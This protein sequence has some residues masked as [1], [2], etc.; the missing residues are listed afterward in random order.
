MALRSFERVPAAQREPTLSIFLHKPAAALMGGVS[1]TFRRQSVDTSA[2]AFAGP[3]PIHFSEIEKSVI[4]AH[5]PVNAR[6]GGW[7][8]SQFEIWG[9]ARPCSLRNESLSQ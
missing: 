8:V 6:S 9:C 4:G 2:F 7:V 3:G 1:V 5:R